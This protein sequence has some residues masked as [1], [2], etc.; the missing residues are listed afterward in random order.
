MTEIYLDNNKFIDLYKSVSDVIPLKNTTKSSSEKWILEFNDNVYFENKNITNGSFFKFFISP[1]NIEENNKSLRYERM[2]SIACNYEY[3][4]YKITEKI[5]K[6]GICDAFP[7]IYF[8]KRNIKLEELVMLL[9][10]NESFYFDEEILID[11]LDKR[12]KSLLSN[13][14]INGLYQNLSSDGTINILDVDGNSVDIKFNKKDYVINCIAIENIVNKD[15]INGYSYTLSEFIANNETINTEVIKVFYQII[16]ILYVFERYKIVHNDLHLGNIMIIRYKKPIYI[17]YCINDV[18]YY[19]ETYYKVIVFDFDRSFN[20]KIGKNVI[21]ENLNKTVISPPDKF[22]KNLDLAKLVVACFNRKYD[23]K[24]LDIIIKNRYMDKFNEIVSF[25]D[26]KKKC[27]LY[28]KC[29]NIEKIL[30]YI[31]DI[32]DIFILFSELLK[33]KD[34]K[35]SGVVYNKYKL[36]YKLYSNNLEKLYML[37]SKKNRTIS[38]FSNKQTAIELRDKL[39]IEMKDKYYKVLLI[40]LNQK[41]PENMEKKII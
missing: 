2:H 28:R 10:R 11:L 1:V 19:F 25:G 3:E 6:K 33:T 15:D 22:T 31:L 17:N 12:L 9:K 39:N 24:F 13:T 27:S 16:Y 20:E 21:L 4:M 18:N 34:N 41:Y 5:R 29:K 7:K 40:K 36:N 32:P 35:I 8:R 37:S 23:K 26:V 14:N 38:I 30:D